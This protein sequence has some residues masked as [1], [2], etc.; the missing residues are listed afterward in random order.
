MNGKRKKIEGLVSK[1]FKLPETA[2]KA[3]HRRYEI[4]FSQEE[5]MK[6]CKK[7]G[8]SPITLLSIMMSRGIQKAYPEYKKQSLVM[9]LWMP[10]IFLAAMSPLKTALRV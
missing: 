7:Y 1:G 8:A 9:F 2:N 6:A 3:D 5:F 10:D 4:R